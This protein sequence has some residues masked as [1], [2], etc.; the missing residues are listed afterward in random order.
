MVNIPIELAN[1]RTARDDAWR[2]YMEVVEAHG[3]KEL[4]DE[5]YKVCQIMEELV[6]NIYKQWQALGGTSDIHSIA[7]HKTDADVADIMRWNDW[8][9]EQDTIKSIRP[10]LY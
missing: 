8:Q 3:S 4:I 7:L 10:T 6:T 9:D 1:A 5:T 2:K